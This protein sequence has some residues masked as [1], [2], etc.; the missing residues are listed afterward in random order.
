MYTIAIIIGSDCFRFSGLTETRNILVVNAL[1]IPPPFHH[2][3]K[4]R[5]KFFSNVL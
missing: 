4:M 1:K 5:Q 3:P 2:P